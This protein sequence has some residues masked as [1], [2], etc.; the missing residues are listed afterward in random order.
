M[1]QCMKQLKGKANP[2]VVTKILD[3]ELSKLK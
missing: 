3:E 1:G 2:A